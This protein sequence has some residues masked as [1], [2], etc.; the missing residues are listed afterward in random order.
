MEVKYFTKNK[1]NFKIML[2]I[3]IKAIYNHKK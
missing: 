3:K 2:D 1:N